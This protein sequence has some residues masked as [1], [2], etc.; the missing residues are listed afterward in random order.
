MNLMEFY[1]PRNPTSI[2][3]SAI[4][5]PDFRVQIVVDSAWN[6][7]NTE[8]ETAYLISS[9]DLKVLVFFLFAH[10]IFLELENGF[11]KPS[12][13]KKIQAYQSIKHVKK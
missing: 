10:F 6:D 8:L 5:I 12:S 1:C 4:D 13:P 11:P 7:Y 2:S 9:F 3:F